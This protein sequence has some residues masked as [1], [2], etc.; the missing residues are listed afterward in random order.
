MVLPPVPPDVD[1]TLTE[2]ALPGPRG[3][4]S[5]VVGARPARVNLGPGAAI[6]HYVVLGRLGA[7]GMGEV[8]KAYDPRLD[9]AVAVKLI[10]R[11]GGGQNEQM[12]REARVLAQLSHPNVI[13][14]HD[15]GMA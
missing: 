8:Y 2:P 4:R 5:D 12:V 13:A 9:R 15:V 11:G 1:E 7:G 10:R 14:V 6:A 3:Q